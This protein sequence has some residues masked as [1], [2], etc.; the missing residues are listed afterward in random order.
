[1]LNLFTIK[2]WQAN[3]ANQSL[4][5]TFFHGAPGIDVVNRLVQQFVIVVFW[6]E[7][8]FFILKYRRSLIKLNLKM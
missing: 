4:L 3:R 8:S 5:D 1:M 6:E 7:L 2:V